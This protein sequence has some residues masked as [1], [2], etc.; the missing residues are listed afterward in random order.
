MKHQQ[1]DLLV[2]IANGEYCRGCM[3]K[4]LTKR[5]TE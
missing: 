1:H 3:A 2:A 5:E 4:E